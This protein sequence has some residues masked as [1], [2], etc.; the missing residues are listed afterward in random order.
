VRPAHTFAASDDEDLHL[1]VG[2]AGPVRA[3]LHQ[4]PGLKSFPV[5]CRSTVITAVALR[6]WPSLLSAAAAKPDLLLRVIGGLHGGAASVAAGAASETRFS[7]ER[8]VA[9]AELDDAVR[10][11]LDRLLADGFTPASPLKTSGRPLTAYSPP[12]MP[13]ATGEGPLV[14]IGLGAND[15]TAGFG[16]RERLHNT[17]D[18]LI[19]TKSSIDQSIAHAVISARGLTHLERGVLEEDQRPLVDGLDGLEATLALDESALRLELDVAL[20]KPTAP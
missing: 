7:P 11:D 5:D 19:P 20:R 17:F 8:I 2:N 1:E 16:W 3:V 4:P 9:I 18:H 14:A 13:W 12:Q 6:R 15:I 10:G